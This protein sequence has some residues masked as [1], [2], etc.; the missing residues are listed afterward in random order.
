M[1]YLYLFLLL[2]SITCTWHV[3]SIVCRKDEFVVECPSLG[4]LK[5]LRIGHDNSGVSPGWFL[6]KV[7]VDDLETHRVYEFPCHRWLAKDEDDGQISR[8]LLC[9]GA[10][11]EGALNRANQ[12]TEFISHQ[13]CI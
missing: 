4:T 9:G 3:R 8:E 12:A 13:L 11:S 7:I 1:G 10:G 2:P 5:R 6:D